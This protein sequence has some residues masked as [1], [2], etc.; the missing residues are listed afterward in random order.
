MR[1]WPISLEVPSAGAIASGRNYPLEVDRFLVKGGQDQEVDRLL[2]NSVNDSYALDV[3]GPNPSEDV[4]IGGDIAFLGPGNRDVSECLE[5][6]PENFVG[7]DGTPGTTFNFYYNPLCQYCTSGSDEVFY[8]LFDYSVPALHFMGEMAVPFRIPC[9]AT[10]LLL[11]VRDA[12]NSSSSYAPRASDGEVVDYYEEVRRYIHSMADREKTVR[13]IELDSPEAMSTFGYGTGSLALPA[14]PSSFTAETVEQSRRLVPIVRRVIGEVNPSYTILLGG[15]TLIPMPFKDD[16]QG[17]FS[18][19]H[20]VWFFRP[21]YDED[22][23]EMHVSKKLYSDDLY[24]M[25][26]DTALPTRVISRIPTPV[27]ED[28]GVQSSDLLVQGL[29]NMAT[30]ARLSRS[31]ILGLIDLCGHTGGGCTIG[32]YGNTVFKL[33]WPAGGM[34]PQPYC[35]Q[36]ASP[37]SNQCQPCQCSVEAYEI[38][39]CYPAPESCKNAYSVTTSGVLI[40]DLSNYCGRE[41]YALGGHTVLPGETW[42]GARTQLSEAGTIFMYSHGAPYGFMVAINRAASTTSEDAESLHLIVSGDDFATRE[43]SLHP[44]VISSACYSGAIDVPR[45]NMSLPMAM[46][47]AGARTYLGN[48][49]TRIFTTTGSLEADITTFMKK[50]FREGKTAG[51]AFLEAKSAAYSGLSAHFRNQALLDSSEARTEVLHPAG[52][53]DMA[54]AFYNAEGFVLYGDPLAYAPT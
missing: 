49:R 16:P 3:Y 28:Y 15:P 8:A 20:G 48:T 7:P 21:A 36:C 23:I 41:L 24:M 31:Q 9:R 30:N 32:D 22:R 5:A 40:R 10:I 35:D 26:Q 27:D 18:P 37:E 12:V 45:E 42:G 46:I 17:L 4:T 2:F 47:G 51:N 34:P 39:G 11:G 33:F 14:N 29:A 53:A 52:L 25:E 54:D 50:M 38:P 1:Y 13:F 44:F 6:V 19:Q 43:L